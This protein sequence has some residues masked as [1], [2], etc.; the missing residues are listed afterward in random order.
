MANAVA[1]RFVRAHVESCSTACCSPTTCISRL[2]FFTRLARATRTCR[3]RPRRL[4]DWW[5]RRTGHPAQTGVPYVAFRCAFRPWA[6][7]LA[8]TSYPTAHAQ[9]SCPRRA[10]RSVPR[11]RSS[12]CSNTVI[13]CHVSPYYVASETFFATRSLR[14]GRIR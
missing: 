13:G 3:S 14:R 1:E 10:P 2:C 9:S 11:Q 4:A 8:S 7:M 6:P 5:C 12:W